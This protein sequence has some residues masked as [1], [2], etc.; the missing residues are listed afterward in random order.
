MYRGVRRSL[1]DVVLWESSSKQFIHGIRILETGQF[2][3]VN[4]NSDWNFDYSACLYVIVISIEQQSLAESSG[5]Y[6][7]PKV[8]ENCN[9]KVLGLYLV[10]FISKGQKLGIILE[11]KVI[12]SFQ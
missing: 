9:I 6:V 10:H 5:R 8:N 4:N 3:R 2:W 11:S 12:Q 7:K 1:L